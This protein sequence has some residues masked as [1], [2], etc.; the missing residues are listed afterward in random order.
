PAEPFERLL[1]LRL[2]GVRGAA[3]AGGRLQLP[4]GPA[5]DVGGQLRRLVAGQEPVHH[6]VRQP[7]GGV[8]RGRRLVPLHRQPP[9]VVPARRARRAAL[10]SPRSS[11]SWRRASWADARA[12]WTA[13]ATSPACRGRAPG[14]AAR[15]RKASS[16]TRAGAAAFASRAV[17]SARS[18]ATAC[19]Q[20]S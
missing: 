4:P 9:V 2:D 7:G 10:F 17:A 11:S 20:T 19:R 3:V 14:S 6:L 5:E 18:A 16:F 15:Q 12:A 1:G 8:V 13:D